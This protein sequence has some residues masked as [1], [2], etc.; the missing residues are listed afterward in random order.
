MRTS[1]SL[2]GPAG[3]SAGEGSYLAALLKMADDAPAPAVP[4][5]DIQRYLFEDYVQD[6][7]GWKRRA[8]Y[9]LKP[10]I[11]RPVQLALRRRYVQVQ[12]ANAFPSWPIERT[13]VDIAKAFVAGSVEANGGRPV[14][15]IAPWPDGNRCAFVITHDVEWD[16]GLRHA[17][18]ILELER[19][20]GF[21]SSW[22]LV[23]E[24][25]PIDWGIVA[26]LRDGG[27][28]IGIHGLKHDGRLFESKRMFSSRLA[29]VEGYARAWGAVGFRSPSTLRNARWMEAMRFEYDS[30]FPDTDPYE[31]QPGGCCSVWPYFLGRMVEL[32]L[33]MP[34]DHTLFEILGHGDLGLWKTKVDWLADAGGLIL[35]NVHPDY[36]M[37]EVRMREYERFLVWMWERDSVWHAHPKDVAQWWRDRDGSSLS[38]SS[39]GR[40]ITGPAG[41][42]GAV[43]RA[44]ILDG[45]LTEELFRPGP[46]VPG[47]R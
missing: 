19:R 22:N 41:D 13:I 21:V 4:G 38:R 37:S 8:Y 40:H 6:S 10:L 29:K 15:R 2:E 23:P 31:P 44:S 43:I 24:R 28:E 18:A 12:A 11:P 30:S 35:I 14:D 32:P 3:A 1:D 47:G 9:A 20:L 16:A 25:Y 33:T 42:R 45:S 7:S 39:D 34:Q 27:G 46:A 36:M 5:E 17:P 26:L